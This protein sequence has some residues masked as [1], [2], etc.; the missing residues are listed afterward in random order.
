LIDR[1]EIILRLTW[2]GFS[3]AYLS[4]NAAS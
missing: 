1:L 2:D 4:K 3:H